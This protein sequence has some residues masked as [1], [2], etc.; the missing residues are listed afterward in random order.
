MSRPD[1]LV[2]RTK[3]VDRQLD[4]EPEPRKTVNKTNPFALDE[5]LACLLKG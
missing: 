5:I 2:E 3:H 4:F 1:R